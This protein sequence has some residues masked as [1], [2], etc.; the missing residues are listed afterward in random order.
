MMSIETKKEIYIKCIKSIN[1]ASDENILKIISYIL[2]NSFEN[3][4]FCGFYFKK[5]NQLKVGEYKS[6][7]IPCSPISLKGVCGTAI[8]KN[9]IVNLPDVK[10]FSDHIVC[11]SNSKSEL[12]IPFFLNSTH[13]VLDVDSNKLNDFD[14]IDIKF[15]TRIIKNI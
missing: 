13:Y 12:C 5:D 3:W 8:L 1:N 11:D 2:F 4:I 9:E 7:K 6:L 14:D 10:E 15:L